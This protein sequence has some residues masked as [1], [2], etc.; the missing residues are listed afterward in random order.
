[1]NENFNYLIQSLIS[2]SNLNKAFYLALLDGILKMHEETKA[3]NR[4]G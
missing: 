2:V 3:K 4:K 1:M